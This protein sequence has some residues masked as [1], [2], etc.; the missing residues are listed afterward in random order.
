MNG[1]AKSLVKVPSDHLRTHDLGSPHGTQLF[2]LS[3]MHDKS[4]GAE[5]CRRKHS[6]CPMTKGQAGGA[7][8]RSI[9]ICFVNADVSVHCRRVG[10]DDL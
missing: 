6:V 7:G 8:S 1:Y 10:H 3:L 2:T 9:L 4:S 5:L